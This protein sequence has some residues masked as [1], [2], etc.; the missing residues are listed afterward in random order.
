MRLPLIA[1]VACV[2]CAL[3]GY[4][5]GYVSGRTASRK[6]RQFD[7]SKWKEG[8]PPSASVRTG[9]RDGGCWLVS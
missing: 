3:V 8:K 5:M 1:L 2:L 9:D 7:P 4:A 6:D